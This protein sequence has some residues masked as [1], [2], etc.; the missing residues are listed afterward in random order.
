MKTNHCKIVDCT[1]R[2]G[3]L[4]N[5]WDFSVD[6]VQQLYAGLNEAGVDYM[7]IGY[8]NS[9]KLLKGAEEAGPWRFLNDDFLRKV[10]PQKGNTKLSALVDVG[11]VDEND[12]LPRSESM[13]DLIR[14][15]CYSKDVDK[16]LALVQTFHDRG[17]ETTLN[18]MALSNVM[19]NELLEAFELIKESSVD[20]VYIVDSYGSLDHNDVKYLVEKFKTHLPN[21]RLGVHT[22]NNM[23]LAFSNTLVAAELGVELLD[24]SV[25]GMGRAA[26]NCPTELLVA[27]LKGTKYNLRPVLGVLEQLMVPLREKE[28]WGYIL[29]Y[30]ITGALDEHPRSAMALRSSAE[31]D[32]VVDFYDKLTTPEVNFDK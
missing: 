7:E 29:P 9:P 30:M 22:H 1:I 13:L 20:V 11:R 26:G 19:E 14:V 15:A 17:Y 6:F 21:K 32:N 10:I 16:A 2:D 18:I 25:Y 12:I 23:Q 3:G 24:A 27:H 5:N 8:K 4:V 28:E 31:K